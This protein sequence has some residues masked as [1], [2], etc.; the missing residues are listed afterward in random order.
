MITRNRG[1]DL[2]APTE[3]GDRRR[4]S[5][6][7]FYGVL[8]D[9]PRLQYL[10]VKG[11]PLILIML[12]GLSLGPWGEQD[13]LD[14]SRQ[15]S[16]WAAAV[17]ALLLFGWICESAAERAISP[18]RDLIS[19]TL[20]LAGNMSLIY[21]MDPSGLG[22]NGIGIGVLLLLGLAWIGLFSGL[23]QLLVAFVVY[24]IAL[25][26][27]CFGW[28]SLS[29]LISIPQA[30]F[31]YTVS[32]IAAGTVHLVVGQVQGQLVRSLRQENLIEALLAGAG[33]GFIAVEKDGTIRRVNEQTCRLVGRSA[34]EIEGLPLISVLK[35]AQQLLESATHDT[36]QIETQALHTSKE[37]VPVMC[38]TSRVKLS[39]TT[40]MMPGILGVTFE[41]SVDHH[42]EEL[43]VVFLHDIIL[44]QRRDS[45]RAMQLEAARLLAR[46]GSTKEV[47]SE[48][49]QI[50]LVPGLWSGFA[51]MTPSRESDGQSLMM[52][53]TVSGLIPDDQMQRVALEWRGQRKGRW[54][55][56]LAEQGSDVVWTSAPS[57]GSSTS[58]KPAS[59]LV[60]LLLEHQPQ[61]TRILAAA[62]TDLQCV[63][64]AW[65]D[66][67]D[68]TDELEVPDQLQG[69]QLLAGQ[70]SQFMGRRKAERELADTQALEIND[71]VVQKLTL[72]SAHL[73]LGDGAKAGSLIEQALTAAKRITTQ[74]AKR[75]G[76]IKPGDLVRRYDSPDDDIDTEPDA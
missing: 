41:H 9:R 3:H 40:Q 7:G 58:P 20:Y 73:H 59:R 39:D 67:Q 57:A 28:G 33:E 26:A 8:Q 75:T 70:V 12:S 17:C 19:F 60:D 63:V 34:H 11:L 71:D 4:I 69:L 62:T 32:F 45:L 52:I 1:R 21:S 29:V 5:R 61:T 25:A 42:S 35:D 14:P 27:I 10:T 24:S 50:A 54:L 43:I 66:R 31:I 56:A 76:S 74:M 55:Q 64:I 13:M 38:F 68:I 46:G 16:L 36:V 6:A 48:L 22:G 44:R 72:A 65:S 15:I 51:I 30:L 47:L 18:W 37:F 49:S 2:A 53:D 23:R